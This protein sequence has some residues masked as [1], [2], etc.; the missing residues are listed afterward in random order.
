LQVADIIQQR[1]F[2]RHTKL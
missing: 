1:L 2:N